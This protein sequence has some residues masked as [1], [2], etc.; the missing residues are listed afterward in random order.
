ML[1]IHLWLQ[2]HL[3]LTP[4]GDRSVPTVIISLNSPC[5]Q[6]K[7]RWQFSVRDHTIYKRNSLLGWKLLSHAKRDVQI[8]SDKESSADIICVKKKILGCCCQ[9]Y[10][11]KL[12]S[13]KAS[14]LVLRLAGT[15]WTFSIAQFSCLQ[16]RVVTS[17]LPSGDKRRRVFALCWLPICVQELCGKGLIFWAKTMLMSIQL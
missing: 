17:K 1:Q 3:R 11:S 4:K 16:S 15:D 12:N 14:F 6:K 5:S 13:A 8:N 7:L 2:V 10:A 9:I